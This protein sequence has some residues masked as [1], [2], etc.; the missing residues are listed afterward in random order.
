[1]ERR[2]AA[3][4]TGED[5]LELRTPPEDVMLGDSINI[6][7]PDE[8]PTAQ[9]GRE[10]RSFGFAAQLGPSAD[11]LARIVAILEEHPAA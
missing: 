8:M 4:L 10:I 7:V 9:N 6:S 11:F 5:E 2:Y 3:V 1:M